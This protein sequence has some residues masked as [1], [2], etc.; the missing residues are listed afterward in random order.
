MLGPICNGTGGG[1]EAIRSI[2]GWV[3]EAIRRKRG[4]GGGAIRIL[5]AIAPPT[6]PLRGKILEFL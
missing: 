6:P 2:L 1:G 4:W 5:V 3:G